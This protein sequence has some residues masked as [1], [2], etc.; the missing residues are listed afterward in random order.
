MK[1]L[2]DFALREKYAKVKKLRSR[3]EEMKKI[4]DW[5]SFLPY[6]P[7]KETAVG[8]NGYNSIFKLQVLFLQ[9]W[10]GISDE[11]MEFQTYNR[12][13]FQQFLDFPEEIPD[14]TTIWRFREALTEENHIDNV[15]EELKR[16]IAEHGIKVKKGKI[17]DA[18]FIHADPGKTNSGMQGRGR[19]AKTSRSKDGSWTKKASLASSHMSKQMKQQN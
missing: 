14:F 8:R 19:E 15:W 7:K 17:Q 1:D 13:D 10:Y 3:L 5:D 4:I 18:S 16:Q 9:S 12:L 6:L 11:E 2:I